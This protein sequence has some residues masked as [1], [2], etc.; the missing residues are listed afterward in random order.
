MS[1]KYKKSKSKRRKS[2][3]KSKRRKSKVKSKRRK[4][5]VKS[6]RR[7]SIN[8]NKKSQALG[9]GVFPDRRKIGEIRSKSFPKSFTSPNRFALLAFSQPDLPPLPEDNLSS[10]TPPLFREGCLRAKEVSS[11][12]LFLSLIDPLIH[13][14]GNSVS[15]N[16]LVNIIINSRYLGYSRALQVD[17]QPHYITRC[18]KELTPEEEDILTQDLQKYNYISANIRSMSFSQQCINLANKLIPLLLDNTF[19]SLRSLNISACILNTPNRATIVGLN[20]LTELDISDST[21]IHYRW[22]DSLLLNKQKLKK[23]NI[24]GNPNLGAVIR[25]SCSNQPPF[26]TLPN[27][28]ILECDYCNLDQDYVTSGWF[29]RLVKLKTL[30]ASN[31]C[32]R[33]NSTQ[34]INTNLRNLT[35]LNLS[36]NNLDDMGPLLGNNNLNSLTYLDLSRNPKITTLVYIKHDVAEIMPGLLKVHKLYLD[37]TNICSATV[38]AIFTQ[39]RELTHLSLDYINS[40]NLVLIQEIS[41]KIARTVAPPKLEYLSMHVPNTS[42]NWMLQTI[43]DQFPKITIDLKP[44][45]GY[46]EDD[47]YTE[48]E[49]GGG[50]G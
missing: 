3:V 27:L 9:D 34:L 31:N 12:S 43:Y 19:P 13:Y 49:E 10:L 17:F 44:F 7:K 1:C 22:P 16:E 42:N 35:E 5:K 30:H 33:S 28:E 11:S 47:P 2:K 29:G 48:D 32:L 14:W 50:W 45:S 15:W 38:L 20:Y 8:F 40:I 41:A 21:H 4:S 26:T 36:S 6:K 25:R 37:S 18:S 23:L 39:L 46:D 24:S